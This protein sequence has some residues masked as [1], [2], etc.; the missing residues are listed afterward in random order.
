MG[1]ADAMEPPLTHLRRRHGALP[2]HLLR[3]FP[4]HLTQSGR[5]FHFVC[6]WP[7][8]F[9]VISIVA[10]RP[11]LFALLLLFDAYV[12]CILVLSCSP[13]FCTMWNFVVNLSYG[14]CM[15]SAG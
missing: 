15:V 1:T 4:F 6:V 5:Y 9:N 2:G 10:L 13:L 12:G 7:M 11:F 8:L 14:E 3:L